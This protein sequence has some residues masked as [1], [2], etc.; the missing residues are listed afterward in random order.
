MCNFLDFDDMVDDCL[1]TLHPAKVN[2]TYTISLTT[3]E[4]KANFDLLR[5][6][7]GWAPAE[8]LKKHSK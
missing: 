8:T 4:H 6:L 5:P 1:D 7:F 3:V 2:K